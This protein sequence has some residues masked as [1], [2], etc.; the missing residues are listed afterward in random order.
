MNHRY[1]APGD[2]SLELVLDSS[3]LKEDVGKGLLLEGVSNNELILG[4]SR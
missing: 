2:H 3:P 1:L 4:E